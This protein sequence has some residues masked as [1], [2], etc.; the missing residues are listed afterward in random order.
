MPDCRFGQSELPTRVACGGISL[1]SNLFLLSS[2]LLL[3]A[4]AFGKAY[5]VSAYMAAHSP[6][7]V[8]RDPVLF[9]WSTSTVDALAAALEILVAVIIVSNLRR[10]IAYLA[11]THLV[12]V[13][14][15]YRLG[16]ALLADGPSAC[17][18]GGA[19]DV[20]IER[21]AGLAGKD[22]TLGLLIYWCAGLTVWWAHRLGHIRQG[23][24]H[25]TAALVS[26][27][28]LCCTYATH[29]DVLQVRGFLS[30][31][32]YNVKGQPVSTQTYTYEVSLSP[33]R[34]RIEAHHPNQYVEVGGGTD[35]NTF[36]AGY[37]PVKGPEQ[38]GV[39]NWFPGPYP[40]GASIGVT[41]PWLAF[42]SSNV[43]GS[44]VLGLELPEPA[45]DPS[46]DPYAHI[47]ENAYDVFPSSGLPR[48]CSF[49]TS[50]RRLRQAT[51]NTNLLLEGVSGTAELERRM[52]FSRVYLPSVLLAKYEVVRTT[53]L[54]G[55]IYPLEFRVRRF[56]SLDM[57]RTRKRM[58]RNSDTYLAATIV[59]VATNF[60][61]VSGD[62]S[63]APPIRKL[64]VY[65]HRLQ[66][67]TLG[68]DHVRYKITDGVW[69]A[70]I[71]DE[72]RALFAARVA[73]AQNA[74]RIEL[75][76]KSL[77][78]VLLVLVVLGPGALYGLWQH[79]LSRRQSHSTKNTTNRPH[80]DEST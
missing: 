76:K 21:I 28:L 9:W 36:W 44:S 58:M 33:E 8:A 6:I 18:C 61:R 22:W 13:F 20:W 37:E 72:M 29:A 66:N 35:S 5:G 17:R 53:N 52:D 7:A 65:D 39:A 55:V 48:H 31:T 59:G 14:V 32:A 27:F 75:M 12:A 41:V 50:M 80:Y 19:A 25:R 77:I 1:V 30:Y 54:D 10:S 49:V 71:D 62:V 3:L 43:L 67:R 40:A 2:A 64:S 15:S 57:V 60:E 42:C 79:R 38:E 51:S 47:F 16:L 45:S 68:I 4:T 23:H 63:L 24:P 46:Y 78:I 73:E 56:G 34:W 11:L 74:R 70:H 26:S 69:K